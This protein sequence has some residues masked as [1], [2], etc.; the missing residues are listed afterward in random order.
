MSSRDDKIPTFTTAR[1]EG[2]SGVISQNPLPSIRWM[3]GEEPVPGY[4]LVRL[5]GRGGFGEVWQALGP[6]GVAV[7]L[8]Y[9]ALASASAAVEAR[10]LTFMKEIRHPHL[11]SLFGIWEVNGCLIIAME[12]AEGTLLDQLE[13]ARK[14][15]HEGIP[16]GKLWEWMLEAGKGLDYLNDGPPGMAGEWVKGVQHRDIKPQNILL[17]GGSV[18]VADFGLAKVMG[19]LLASHSGSMTLPYA[20]PEFFSGHTARTSD[21]YSLAVTY[22]HLRG[23]RLPF[24]GPPS[25]IMAGHIARDPDLTMLPPEERPI[26]ARALSKDPTQRWP[27]CRIFI[28]ALGSRPTSGNERLPCDDQQITPIDRRSEITSRVENNLAPSEADTS[29]MLRNKQRCLSVMAVLMTLFLMACGMVQ[30]AVNVTLEKIE[31]PQK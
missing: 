23:G 30:R 29:K 13:A 20:A 8:K 3:E 25:E 10:A 1:P 22:C 16:I 26:V 6:G 12:L 18:K 19:E 11:M 28:E 14:S 27:N 4:R 15:G 5:L 2:H 7:A 9:L 24:T 17:V 31:E 21:Q